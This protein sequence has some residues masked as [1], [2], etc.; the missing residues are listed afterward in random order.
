MIGPGA[1]GNSIRAELKRLGGHIEY[2]LLTVVSKG[3]SKI[4]FLAKLCK[5]KACAIP[6]V[7]IGH[8]LQTFYISIKSKRWTG[9]NAEEN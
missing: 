5:E 4:V 7:Y 9:M 8:M 1:D 3:T 6:S 2:C